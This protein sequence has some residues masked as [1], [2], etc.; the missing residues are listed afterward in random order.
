MLR[1]AHYIYLSR[2]ALDVNHEY[3]IKITCQFP[4]SKRVYVEQYKAYL[5]VCLGARFTNDFLSAI[6]I[7]WK[8]SLAVIPL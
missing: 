8:L 6:Q 4:T 3:I 1:N 7:R 2:N 5:L